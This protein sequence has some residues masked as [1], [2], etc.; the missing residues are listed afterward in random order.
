MQRFKAKIH[1]IGINPYVTPPDAVLTA[2]F[3]AAKRSTSPIPVCGSIEKTAFTQTLVRYQGAWRL[4]LNTPMRRGADKDLGDT[5][6]F[7]LRFDPKPPVTP[8]PPALKKALAAQPRAKRAFEALS[9]SRR[10]EIMRY[11][12]HLK[13]AEA[14]AKNLGH[15]MDYLRGRKPQGMKPVLRLKG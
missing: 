11:L 7:S 2:L 6:Q 4:Y 10:K 13:G 14:L 12:G 15:T 8:M 9:P 1:I 5:A 3:K